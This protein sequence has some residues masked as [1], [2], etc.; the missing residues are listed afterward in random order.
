VR[1]PAWW[2]RRASA[3][4]HFAA[5]G[6]GGGD[7]LLVELLVEIG[8]V[9]DVVLVEGLAPGLGVLLLAEGLGGSSASSLTLRAAD[10]RGLELVDLAEVT[11]LAGHV[12][13]QRV[14]RV[15]RMRPR[16]SRP[17]VLGP[18]GL[19]LLGSLSITGHGR[20]SALAGLPVVRMTPAPL[21]E[22]A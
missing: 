9:L 2:A 17:G 22:L 18:P 16:R 5:L 13:V 10:D 21:A 7:G 19:A 14:G 12:V 3:R 6:G 8:L 11:Q 15:V 4:G 1:G 20:S